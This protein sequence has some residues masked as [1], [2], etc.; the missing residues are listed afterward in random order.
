MNFRLL[1]SKCTS[2]LRR[3]VPASAGEQSALSGILMPT[4]AS[5]RQGV[6]GELPNSGVVENA[7]VMSKCRGACFVKNLRNRKVNN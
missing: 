6:A 4:G 1:I 2:Q 7:H 5:H 3:A